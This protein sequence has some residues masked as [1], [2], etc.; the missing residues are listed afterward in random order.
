M[1]IHSINHSKGDTSDVG[2]F[3]G[4]VGK[5]VYEFL[6]DVEMAFLAWGNNKQNYLKIIF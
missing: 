2:I 4:N 6:E 3:T 1:E 5:S